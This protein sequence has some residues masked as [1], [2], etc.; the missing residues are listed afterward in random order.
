MDIAVFG[1]GYVGAVSVACLAD[2]GHNVIGVDISD[3][4]V[5][6]I[7]RGLSPII[8][9]DIGPL[10]SAMVSAGRVRATSD[11]KQAVRETEMA[12]VCVGT[13]SQA[14]GSIDL[15]YLRR[16]SEQI[17]LAIREK[18]GRY[19]A[20]VRCTTIPG[21]TRDVVI[22]SISEHS[23]KTVSKEF[24]VCYHPE[25]LREGSGIADFNQP[26]KIVIGATDTESEAALRS[27]YPAAEAPIISTSLEVAETVKYGDNAWHAVKINFA[28]E[29][30][31]VSKAVG[32]DGRVVM[33]IFCQDHKL[34]ISEKYLRPGF[35]FGG[36]CLGKDLRALTHA[37]R[38][39]DLEL[40]MLNSL[41]KSNQEH[42]DRALR[43][44]VQIGHR[45]VGLVG[46]SFKKGTDDLRESPLVEL[47]ERLIGKGFDVRIF[48]GLVSLAKVAGAN[49]EYVENHLPH[50]SDIMVDS[51]DDL[52]RHARTIVVGHD[53]ERCREA[54]RSE[55][56]VGREV[57]DL[58]GMFDA[59]GYPMAYQGIG[60]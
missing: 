54:L 38:R 26:G 50:L 16:V 47:A 56:L 34:N 43:M 58:V 59:R 45:E 13:P 15:Q 49:R 6:L 52:L 39:L 4:K 32:V 42:I 10:M 7:N 9:A 31:T 21:T 55:P 40:P 25:F 11:W 27:I 29:L 28:N 53:D 37:A 3:A 14:N 44:I 5:D 17:G 30:A 33:E 2:R 19:V 46:L 48:D 18:S 35:A 1:L 8:E 60:W 12:W 20:V 41:L 36:S 57:V 24:G 23:R 51:M 22:P